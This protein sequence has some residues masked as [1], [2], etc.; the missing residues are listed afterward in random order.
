[1][2]S[3]FIFLLI[4]LI[5]LWVLALN[6]GHDLAFSLAYLLSGVLILSY[7]LA[8]SS[9]R[10]VGI[11]RFTRTQRSQVG[12][13]VEEIFEVSNGG[14]LA[15]L[16]LEV[17]DFS[18][19]PGHSAS[20]VI[21]SLGR[22]SSERWQIRTPCTHRG[23]FRLGPM[24]LRSGDPLGIFDVEQDLPA[25]SN[26]V[27]YPLVVPLETFEPSVSDLSGGEAR[28]QRTYQI[29]T[30]VATV[31]DYAPGDSLNRIH[32][33]ST[34]RARRLMTKEFELDPTADVW[35]YLD[36]YEGGQFDLPWE[37]FPYQVGVFALSGNRNRKQRQV[38]LPPSTTEYGVTIAASL[39]HYF[40]DKDRA[41]GMTSYG[42][43]REFLQSDRG[44]RQKT[45][46]LEGLAVVE[47]DG[48]LPFAQVIATDSVRLN[49]NDTILAISA[50]PD[51]QW[52]L[53]LQDSQRRGI[54]SIAVV[55]D[56]NTFGASI[57]YV[58][59]VS[60]FEATGLSY[61]MVE[62]GEPI[63]TALSKPANKTHRHMAVR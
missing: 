41:V 49:R 50:D 26:I 60:N 19:L 45:K 28:R 39:A 40:L 58:P 25:T 61:Y 10:S 31:R 55:I 33:P 20:R 47:G 48:N 16:W 1:M 9:T 14:V 18:K 35:I 54:N 57:D 21:S 4:T 56:G 59:V 37:V 51:P 3:R 24:V 22:N 8:W 62:R 43:T 11:R 29:T 53:A 15:K 34:A 32:W 12:Q 27:V 23:R 36:L 42:K 30:N 46:I 17:E 5:T 63:A 6:S 38:E 13:F 52:A 7:F 2:S 44:E